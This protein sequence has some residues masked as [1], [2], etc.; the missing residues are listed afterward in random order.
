V[1]VGLDSLIWRRDAWL[2]CGR[3]FKFNFEENQDE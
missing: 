2:E 3:A 1:A